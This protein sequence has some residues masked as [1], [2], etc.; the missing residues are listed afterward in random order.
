MLLTK[1]HIFVGH[2]GFHAVEK[3]AQHLQTGIHRIWTQHTLVD[4]K[5]PK[6]IIYVEK[7][8]RVT[9]SWDYISIGYG[10]ATWFVDKPGR[11]TDVLSVV[12]SAGFG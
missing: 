6:N 7:Q 9:S 5:Q 2:L 4:R 8:G 1:N 12:I 3:N 11:A 10:T